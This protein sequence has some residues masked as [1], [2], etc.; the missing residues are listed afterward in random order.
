MMKR[1]KR[2][3]T[4]IELIF[5][6]VIMAVIAKFGME[7]LAQAYRNYLY[8]HIDAKLHEQSAAAVEYIASKLQYR[9]KDSVIIRK[10]SDFKAL[11]GEESATDY[12]VLEWIAYDIEGFRGESDA[13]PLW[14]GLIDKEYAHQA[15][16]PTDIYSPG[17]DTSKV[18]ELLEALSPRDKGVDNAAIYIMSSDSDVKLDYGWDGAI[19]DQTHALHPI[20]KDDANISKFVSIWDD[21]DFTLLNSELKDARYKLCQTAYAIEYDTSDSDN[22]KLILHYDYRPWMGEKYNDEETKKAVIMEHVS[23]FRKRQSFGVIKIQ[24]CTK[25]SFV[26]RADTDEEQYSVCKEKT[27][28]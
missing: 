7:F 8:Q 1:A 18:N 23:T 11:E 22:K 10:G 17:T 16:T 25:S 21:K 15:A 6:I 3:F 27:I 4:F 13:A 20:K 24:V 12:D 2:A 26:K 5:V 14:S 28:Y 19:T 9:I